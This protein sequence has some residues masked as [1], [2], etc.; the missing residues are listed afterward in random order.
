MFRIM[1]LLAAIGAGLSAGVFLAFSTFVMPGIR[2]LPASSGVA[3]MQHINKL[4]PN[5]WFMT[6]LLGPALLSLVLGVYAIMRLGSPGAIYLLIGCA[7]YLVGIIV[8]ITY[9]V[10]HN[11]ALALVD[12]NS[13]NIAKTWTDYYQPWMLWNHLRALTCLGGAVLFTL[14]WRLG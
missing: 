7:V 10:P 14:A 3:A 4:A 13:P 9:H 6:V 11:D 1:T 8:T 5:P 2:R 12:V